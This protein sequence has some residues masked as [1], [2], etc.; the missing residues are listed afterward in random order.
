VGTSNGDF[1]GTTWNESFN[2]PEHHPGSGRFFIC[3]PQST[4]DSNLTRVWQSTPRL[5]R[6]AKN[7]I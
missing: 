3:G 2:D 7:E 4:A 6:D 1:S 5:I